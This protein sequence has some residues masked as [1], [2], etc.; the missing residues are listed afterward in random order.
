MAQAEGRVFTALGRESVAVEGARVEAW[1]VEERRQTDRVLLATWWLLEKSP[2][3]VYGE[4]PLPNGRVRKMT[5]VE[6]APSAP[7]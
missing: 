7:R 6:V 3:M 4:V 1:K 2:Y 5:E